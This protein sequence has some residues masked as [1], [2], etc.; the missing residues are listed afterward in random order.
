ME[1]DRGVTAAEIWEHG[2]TALRSQ[3]APNTWG[4]WFEGVRAVGLDDDVLTLAVPSTLAADRIR[5]SYTGMLA[6]TLRDVTGQHLRVELTVETDMR[7]NETLPPPPPPTTAPLSDLPGSTAPIDD[8]EP[9]RLWA[10]GGL[11][12]RYTFDQF[13]IGG[14]NRFAHAA[15]L[16]VAEAPARSYNPLFIYGAAGL[17]KTHLLHAIGHHVKAVFRNKRVRYVSTETFMNEFVDAIRAKTM[18][19]FKRRYRDLDVLLIDDIQFLERTQE[20]QEE[21]FHTFNQLH[22]EDGQI[23]I[24]SDRPPKS[25][26]TLEDRLRSR[27]EWGLI[28]DVQVPEFETRLA[29]LRKKSEAE[30]LDGIPDEVFAFIAGNIH[31]NVRELEGALL[32]VN[33]YRALNDAPL[34]DEI[35][36]QVLADLLSPAQ[37]REITP[38]L[39]LDETAKMFG[40]TVD[41]LCGKSRRRP[42]VTARQIGMY[43][44]RELTGYSYPQI[45][46]EFGG[47]DHTTVMYA[48]EKIKQQMNERHTTFDQVTELIARIKLGTGG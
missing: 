38:E 17:G 20:L 46:K 39:I 3:L 21:F 29:I 45:A 48:V 10:S 4:L 6:D 14:S 18:P 5:S 1:F 24:S 43:V 42:L 2:A 41:D 44:M 13:V 47:R 16:S 9:S 28:T 27:F 7:V 23:V 36:H 31:D 35:A 37:P 33:A 8:G 22:N 11:N 34:T 25:I 40:W 12:P 32:R 30:H 15:A 19:A 26:A